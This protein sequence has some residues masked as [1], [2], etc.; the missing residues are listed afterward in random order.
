MRCEVAIIGSGIAGAISASKFQEQGIDFALINDP[1]SIKH[2]PVWI[3]SDGTEAF[4][5][6]RQSMRETEYVRLISPNADFRVRHA[7]GKYWIINPKEVIAGIQER[8]D[9]SSKIDVDIARNPISLKP[10]KDGFEIQGLSDVVNCKKVV[11]ATG[12]FGLTQEGKN[13]LVEWLYGGAI[14][15]SLNN[16]EMILLFT[17]DGG[18]CW[19]APSIY[20]GYID[21]VYTAWGPKNRYS[22]FFETGDRRLKSLL[23]FA[24]TKKGIH[25]D[26]D[27]PEEIY[28][29]MIAAQEHSGVVCETI[30]PFGEA[31]QTSRP[32]SQGSF[33][34]ILTTGPILTEAV[35]SGL[36]AS[37]FIKKLNMF[38]K[39]DHFMFAGLVAR[40]LAH[41]SKGVSGTTIEAVERLTQNLSLDEKRKVEDQ[42]ESWVHGVV[43]P[44]FVVQMASKDP[45][46]R[47]S[48]MY[49]GGAYILA[50]LIGCNNLF[51]LMQ[52]FNEE[53][54][55][56]GY[57]PAVA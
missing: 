14:R 17:P 7:I 25:I 5:E 45:Q 40:V 20:Q 32:A 23:T 1:R 3:S 4:P 21:A 41:Q 6:I 26:S 11:D 38:Q 18:T 22:D 47:K 39:K 31:A 16:E 46:I 10:V 9:P 44:K 2:R 37:K 33:N 57:L 36:P 24:R 30:Y 28:T 48:L 53:V 43:N 51:K 50:R 55:Q 8:I 12:I 29:G 13:Y 56:R 52:Y 27:I 42:F 49:S 54:L 15:G 19:I 34:R 35:I